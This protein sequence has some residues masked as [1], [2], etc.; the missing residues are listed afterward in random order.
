MWFLLFIR[1]LPV[2]AMS[3][4]KE[5]VPPLMRHPHTEIEL[6]R[7]LTEGTVY[8]DDTGASH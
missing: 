6:E 7:D 4:I 2:M 3:E 5:I 8:P 1:Q